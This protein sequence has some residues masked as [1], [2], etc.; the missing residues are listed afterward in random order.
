MP[1]ELEGPGHRL[2]TSLS[3]PPLL[4]RTPRIL[5]RKAI[6][7][8]PQFDSNTQGCEQRNLDSAFRVTSDVFSASLS[9]APSRN[10][11]ARAAH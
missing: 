8:I 5:A 3:S 7:L 1:A 11:V 6:F 9:V 2:S 10:C 4:P